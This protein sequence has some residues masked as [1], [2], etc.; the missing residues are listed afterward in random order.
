MTGE[1]LQWLHAWNEGLSRG[2]MGAG[3]AELKDQL[4]EVKKQLATAPES[5]ELLEQKA[6]LEAALK[7]AQAKK[8]EDAAAAGAYG[9]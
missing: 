7:A 9:L 1:Q 3:V 5:V 4:V 6:V 8:S 2:G